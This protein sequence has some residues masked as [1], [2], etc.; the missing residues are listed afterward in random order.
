MQYDPFMNKD[1]S[2][3]VYSFLNYSQRRAGKEWHFWGTGYTGLCSRCLCSV[4]L[5]VLMFNN[6]VRYMPYPFC[7]WN[8]IFW[9][10]FLSPRKLFKTTHVRKWQTLTS[11][12]SMSDSKVCVFSSPFFLWYTR[13]QNK[14]RKCIIPNFLYMNQI[15]PP[16]IRFIE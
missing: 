12:P 10:T 5:I 2:Y 1:N 3:C 15:W 13:I 8:K 16:S 7:T 9:A 4:I 11:S 6:P 14:V